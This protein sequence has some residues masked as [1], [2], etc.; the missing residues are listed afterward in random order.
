MPPPFY[1]FRFHA[2][3]TFHI[4]TLHYFLRLMI[5]YFATRFRQN[6]IFSGIL[7]CYC[8]RLFFIFRVSLYRL[9]RHRYAA[10]RWFIF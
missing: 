10:C 5:A 4:T 2:F 6:I 7:P 9:I 1:C 3:I 8:L